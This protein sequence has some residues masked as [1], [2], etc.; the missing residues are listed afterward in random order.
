MRYTTVIQRRNYMQPGASITWDLL[1][2]L[3]GCYYDR[4]KFRA[5]FGD[6]GTT[7]RL[8]SLIQAARANLDVAWF[9]NTL[10]F[11]VHQ[12]PAKLRKMQLA[13]YSSS[14]RFGRG[15][16]KRQEEYR[17]E[18]AKWLWRQLRVYHA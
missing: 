9:A 5:E 6:E 7:L 10:G 4:V 13:A 8:K 15:K 16:R 3:G 12:A 18:V 11:Y 2:D 17:V 14:P 1:R